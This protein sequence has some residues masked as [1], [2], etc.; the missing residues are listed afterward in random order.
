MLDVD[1]RPPAG[2]P[3][4]VRSA[5]TPGGKPAPL[6]GDETPLLDL[7]GMLRE[8][9]PWLLSAAVHMLAMII[10]GVMLVQAQQRSPLVLDAGYSEEFGDPLDEEL[11]LT[12][13]TFEVDN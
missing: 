3:G 9:P 2:A 13:D 6:P 1:Q 5:A 8:S 4:A 7:G 10:F 12:Q 11:D